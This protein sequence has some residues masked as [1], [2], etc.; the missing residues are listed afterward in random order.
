MST[1]NFLGTLGKDISANFVSAVLVI[2]KRFFLVSLFLAFWDKSIYGEWLFVVS[3][4]S[5]L[6]IF[7]F[8]Q[9]QLVMNRLNFLHVEG[10]TAEYNEQ[11]SQLLSFLST[12]SFSVICLA[13]TVFA[14]F[15]SDLSSSD[16]LICFVLMVIYFGT[17][18]ALK[19]IH[20]I[21]KSKQEFHS[22]RKYLNY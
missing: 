12:I 8:G 3:I 14:I 7:T 11:L 17:Q 6:P 4:V 10:K 21:Y 13:I 18:I 1:N 5:F 19:S 22:A 2:L 16:V 9:N 20:D 15:F